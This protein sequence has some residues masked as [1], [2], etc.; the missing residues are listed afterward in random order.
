MFKNLIAP[1]QAWLLSQG[2]CV[3]VVRHYPLVFPKKSEVKKL[4]LAA[5]VEFLSTKKTVLFAVQV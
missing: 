3:V 1:I 2:R 4:L 5:V